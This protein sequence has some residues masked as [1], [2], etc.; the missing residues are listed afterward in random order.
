LEKAEIALF[1]TGIAVL[2]EIEA[3]DLLEPRLGCPASVKWD[4]VGKGRSL[5]PFGWRTISGGDQ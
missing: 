1:F 5:R 4:M 2:P 3:T